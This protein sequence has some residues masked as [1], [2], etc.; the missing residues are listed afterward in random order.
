MKTSFSVSAK[1]VV[2]GSHFFYYGKILNGKKCQFETVD[3]FCQLQMGDVLPFIPYES[4]ILGQ[5]LDLISPAE[6]NL[7]ETRFKSYD[8]WDVINCPV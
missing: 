5:L 3:L 4:P 8:P 6:I 7:F 1:N 2:A